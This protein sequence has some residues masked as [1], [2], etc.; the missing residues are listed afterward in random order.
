MIY[1]SRLFY[2][3]VAV[4]F[5]VIRFMSY[6]KLNNLQWTATCRY[7][8][9]V[10]CVRIKIYSILQVGCMVKSI[11]VNQ[12]DDIVLIYQSNYRFRVKK[13]FLSFFMYI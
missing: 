4:E 7:R 9:H 2:C 11:S 5:I 6:Q 12:I 8:L 10:L 1:F 13:F 3:I